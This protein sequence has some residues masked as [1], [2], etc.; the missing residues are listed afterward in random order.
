MLTVVFPPIALLPSDHL[1][2]AYRDI[3]RHHLKTL[4]Q[5]TPKPIL[6]RPSTSLCSPLWN[7]ITKGLYA[8]EGSQRIG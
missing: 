2:M 7:A 4:P 5:P 6:Q 1:S 3:V 8:A